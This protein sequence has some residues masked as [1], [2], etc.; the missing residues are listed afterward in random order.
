[1]N[2]AAR[3]CATRACVSAPRHCPTSL[4]FA[5][6]HPTADTG[7]RL[8]PVLLVRHVR[9]RHPRPPPSLVR[10]AT[11]QPTPDGRGPL[12]TAM[13]GPLSPPS[14]ASTW[15][16]PRRPTPLFPSALRPDMSSLIEVF[17]CRIDFYCFA[18]HQ[19]TQCIP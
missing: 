9:P 11:A 17:G 1:L 7:S 6:P 2:R 8:A 16:R 13:P 12:L 19:L 3:R 14:P 10:V 15:T 18:L 5:L 4:P